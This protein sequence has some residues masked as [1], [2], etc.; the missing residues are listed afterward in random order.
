MKKIN[1]KKN[2]KKIQTLQRKYTQSSEAKEADTRLALLDQFKKLLNE[3][4]E[5]FL[6]AL[7][8]DLA[9]PTLEAYATEIGI[10]LN[11][12]DFIQKHLPTWMKAE[13]K[14]RYLLNGVEKTTVCQEPYGSILVL[15]PW[16]YPLQLALSPVIGALS[17]GNAV[18]L[19]PSESAPSVSRLLSELVPQYFDKQVFH[20]VE[21][22]GEIARALTDLIWDFVF[23]TGSPTIAQDVYQKAA[24]RLTPVVLELGGKN[25]C[26]VD[27]SGFTEESVRKIIWGKFLNTGQTCIAPDTV[28]VHE[29]FYSDFL[30]AAEKQLKDFYGENPQTSD[31]YGRLVHDKH[32]NKMREFL[33]DGD[34]YYGGDIDETTLYMSP[35]LMTHIERGSALDQEEIFGPILPVVPYRDIEQITLK[36]RDMPTPLVTYLFSEKRDTI[37]YVRDQIE[38]GSLSINEVLV[39]ASSPHVPFGGKGMSGIGNYHG[40]ASFDTFTYD[41][42]VY[43]KKTYF[44]LPQQFPPYAEKTLDALRR[45]RKRIY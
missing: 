45:F 33:E 11:E 21:G 31:D 32:L 36:Y 25:P 42:T 2:I 4:E 34:I 13:V 20:V 38:S 43:E 7:H 16:N 10:L 5:A 23:F 12:I 17:A 24:K 22:N 3:N 30:Q 37:R 19:K 6:D 9:K 41:R 35:T 40:E 18:V 8:Q 14:R 29:S 15:A 27:S 44:E 1:F 28:Y 26:I 39:H